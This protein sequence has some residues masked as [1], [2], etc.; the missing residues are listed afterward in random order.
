MAT[1]GPDPEGGGDV[2]GRR[3]RQ[4]GAGVRAEARPPPRP[5]VLERV[6]A[7]RAPGGAALG[8][9]R[10]A[11]RDGRR[12]RGSGSWWRRR[13][14]RWRR[15]GVESRPRG[16]GRS[17]PGGMVAPATSG[18]VESRLL[19]LLLLLL[20]L[21]L[22]VLLLRRRRRRRELLRPGRELRVTTTKRLARG[23]LPCPGPAGRELP[24]RIRRPLMVRELRRRPGRDR[25]SS[26]EGSESGGGRDTRDPGH[27]QRRRRERR[28]AEGLRG[29][30]CVR[31]L[32]PLRERDGMLLLLLRGDG[33]GAAAV[34]AAQEGV[35]EGA[36]G[37]CRV[38]GAL[39]VRR[40]RCA[41]SAGVAASVP[42]RDEVSEAAHG[43]PR[44]PSSLKDAAVKTREAG[45]RGPARPKKPGKG[46][47]MESD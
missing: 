37:V 8:R 20:V 4:E 31:L 23:K 34:A 38:G 1:A 14:Q 42:S 24:V 29:G 18:L 39:M 22:V 32:L 47:G 35:R 15:S 16:S 43:P 19:L 36:E 7:V 3:G 45:K 41:S 17:P 44:Q 21:V 6:V 28:G 13:R 25:G 9:G 27:G 46:F 5:R 26:V 2:R 12:G 30:R 10:A 40:R 11:G 33:D